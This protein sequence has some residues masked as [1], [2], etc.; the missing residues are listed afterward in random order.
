MKLCIAIFGIA[1][2]A[3]LNHKRSRDQSS[4]PKI[5]DKLNPPSSAIARPIACTKNFR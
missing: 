1:L 5:L 3:V 4:A 2:K